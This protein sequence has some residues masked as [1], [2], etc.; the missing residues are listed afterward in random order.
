MPPAGRG[1]R[2][3]TH[4]NI[5]SLEYNISPRR[6]GKMAKLIL[7]GGFLGSGKTTL[8]AET[9]KKLASQGETVG[10]VTNDQ[11]PE[12]VDTRLLR[13]TGM[14]VAEVAGSC[15][16]CNFDGFIHSVQSLISQG[17]ET[18]LAEPVGS[19][20]DL[21]ATVLNP[22]KKFHHDWN[23]L[24]LTVLVDPR[25]FLE[26]FGGQPSRMETDALY[27]MKL[28]MEEADRI[29]VSKS[30]TLSR[31]EKSQIP[32]LL[33]NVFPEKTTGLISAR[34]GE[35]MED[36][37]TPLLVAE[38]AGTKI[39]PVDYDRY[40]H[41]EAVLGWLNAAVA[42]RVQPE[43]S[44]DAAALLTGLLKAFQSEVQKSG[45]EIGHVKAVFNI[46]QREFV[47]N[48]TSLNGTVHV[49]EVPASGDLK[50]TANRLIFNAR[51]QM[52]PESLELLVRRLFAEIL[53]PFGIEIETLR[54]LMPGRP[55][56]THRFSEPA[57]EKP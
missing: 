18:V 28:Q 37:L 2:L 51:V 21:S 49:R 16:C 41:G 22:V 35:G 27:I 52:S 6:G 20:T 1:S 24:P 34:T 48:L 8:L 55:N 43:D 57:G 14:E 13:R 54:S 15:F 31:E 9:A 25:R 50:E 32:T 7:I 10:L 36:W 47:A 44:P 40:A 42:V 56:P 33:K 3:S 53:S 17:A 5:L 30:D 39:V 11:A 4:W 12:L 38:D 29:L 26:I 19:C 23:L 46:H 45:S